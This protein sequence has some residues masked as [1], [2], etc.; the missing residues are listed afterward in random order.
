MSKTRSKQDIEGKWGDCSNV[1]KNIKKQDT[2]ITLGHGA[3][4]KMII[5][6]S[7]F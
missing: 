7:I 2:E 6:K 3:N 5:E 4:G 1:F